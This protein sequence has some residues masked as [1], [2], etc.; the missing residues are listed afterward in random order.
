MN[1][2]KKFGLV[3]VVAFTMCAFN[4]CGDDSGSSS[5]PGD[6]GGDFTESSDSRE[7]EDYSSDSEDDYSSDSDEDDYSSASDDENSSSSSRVIA[8]SSSSH[9][10]A[11][12]AGAK[13]SSGSSGNAAKVMP[14]GYYKTNCPA[15][16]DCKDATSSLEYLNQEMLAIGKYGEMLDTRD[17][18]VYKTT[19]ICD[20]NNENCQTWMAQNLNYRY[21]GV[22]YSYSGYTSDSTS[23]CYGNSA[24]CDKYG[25]LYTWSAVM[26]SAARFSVNAETKCGYGKTCTPNSPHRGICPEGWHVPTNEEYSSLYKNIGGSNTAGS[27]LKSTSGWEDNGDKSGNGIDRYGFS[28]VPAGFKGIGGGMKNEHYD[29]VLWAASEDDSIS[30]WI[31]YFYFDHDYAYQGSNNKGISRSLRCL[32]D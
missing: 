10:I 5:G 18:Q 23:W 6:N 15:G 31:Q 4:A 21:V 30:A 9:V 28:V 8:S 2:I 29:A 11:S 16:L 25:R 14:T 26:D 7:D 1:T 22:K 27:L 12:S 19:E 17:G 24:N 13:Q 32:K 20:S 3:S